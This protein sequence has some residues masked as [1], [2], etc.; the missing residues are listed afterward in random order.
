MAISNDKSLKLR[1][2]VVKTLVSGALEILSTTWTDRLSPSFRDERR[3]LDKLAE[4]LT[5]EEASGYP[6]DYLTDD[7]VVIEQTQQIMVALYAVAI[8]HVFEQHMVYSFYRWAKH[9]LGQKPAGK[10]Q[11]NDVVDSFKV[12]WSVDLRTLRSWPKIDELRLV[13]N[14]VK[15]GEGDS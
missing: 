12:A 1:A 8:Y 11:L 14:C 15:H 7:Y 10:P 3:D 2:Y 9:C 4:K 6:D 5:G 13:A